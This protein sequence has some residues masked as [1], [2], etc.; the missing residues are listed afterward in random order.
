MRDLPKAAALI[1]AAGRSSR[2]GGLKPLLILGSSMLLELAVAQFFKAG[3][4]DVR[5]VLGHRAGEIIPVVERLG[6]KW[7]LNAQYSE[8]M[9]SS[10][11]AGVQ[12]LD[13][14]VEAFF[15]LPVDIPLVKPETIARLL[16]AYRNRRA[17]VVYPRFEGSRGHPPLIDASCLQEGDLSPDY[18]GGLR[19]LLRR[20]ESDALD[21]D[22]EDKAILMDCDTPED[23][24]ELQT[25]IGES[26]NR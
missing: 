2:M 15:I 5:V 8:G 12:D 19:A 9:F 1:L 25:R 23:Y 21:V 3:I 22:V 24:R 17:K 16:S 13:A 6:V 18:P 26:V 20:Y 10:V 11:L 4:E 14:D 7:I